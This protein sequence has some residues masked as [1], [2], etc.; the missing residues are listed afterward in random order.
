MVCGLSDYFLVIVISAGGLEF[1]KGHIGPAAL[2]A[3]C[4]SEAQLVCIVHAN[5][6]IMYRPRHAVLHPA[7]DPIKTRQKSSE[8]ARKLEVESLITYSIHCKQKQGE[9][10]TAA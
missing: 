8:S 9:K 2:I 3:L 1:V 6:C 5:N 10:S 7:D 4:S